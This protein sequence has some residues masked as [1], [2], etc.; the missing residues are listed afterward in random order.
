MLPGEIDPGSIAGREFYSKSPPYSRIFR[1]GLQRAA[2]IPA[3]NGHGNARSVARVGSLL[4]CGGTLNEPFFL[5]QETVFRALEE[6]ITTG[7]RAGAS[8]T[9]GVRVWTGEPEMYLFLNPTIL[10][11][12]QGLEVPGWKWTWST[13]SSFFLR[14]EQAPTKYGGRSPHVFATRCSSSPG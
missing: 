10:S 11:T 12:G 14:D 8:D 1:P 6:Q 2:E 13:R 7:P 9:L 5:S 4:S 3:S